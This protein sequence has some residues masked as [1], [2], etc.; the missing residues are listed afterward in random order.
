VRGVFSKKA[1]AHLEELLIGKPVEVLVNPE[2]WIVLDKRPDQVTGVIHLSKGAPSDVGS[3]LLAE[4]LVRFNRPRPYTMS[5]Y[6]T[7]QYRRL[8]AEAQSNKLGL[9]Q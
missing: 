3:V 4:G 7:C 8:E 9:W 2:K 5:A 6:T 1:K